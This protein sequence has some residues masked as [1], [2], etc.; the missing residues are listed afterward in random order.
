PT[1]KIARDDRLTRRRCRIESAER[2]DN[3][4]RF[5]QISR[6]RRTLTETCIAVCVAASRNVER[7]AR[8][9]DE[10]Q[11]HADP[12][13]PSVTAARINK[14]QR[15]EIATRKLVAEIVSIE[16]RTTLTAVSAP[17]F[18]EIVATP[19]LNLLQ[20]SVYVQAENVP[21]RATGRLVLEH[22][23]RI[24]AERAHTAGRHAGN[25]RPAERRVD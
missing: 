8:V 4:A 12:G 3:N 9:T 23:P 21:D 22:V 16:R 17:R 19:K 20:R 15:A 18:R 25:E 14:I 1:S 13:W 11:V 10:K 5:V 24:G 7:L 2:R 6:K